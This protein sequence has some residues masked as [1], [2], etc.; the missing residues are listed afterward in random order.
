MGREGAYG[1]PIMSRIVGPQPQRYA[2]RKQRGGNIVSI[3]SGKGGVGKTNL[4]LNFGIVLARQGGQPVLLDAD[5][6]LANADILLDITPVAG[7]A[8]LLDER[9][10]VEDLL[11]VAPGGLRVLCGVSGFGDAARL[12]PFTDHDCLRGL[13]R[14]QEACDTLLVDCGAGVNATIVSVALASDLLVMVTTP[15]PTSLA[16][17]YGTLKLLAHHGFCGRAGVVVNMARSPREADGVADRLRHVAHEFLG[18]TVEP[19]GVVPFDR[20]VLEAVRAR[21]PVVVRA[22]RCPASVAI[23]GICRR[24]A[25]ARLRSGRSGGL[26]SRVAS[27]FV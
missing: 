11:A 7:F 8:E 4:A 26:W 2:G 6:G 23:A 16:D 14:L 18:L 21:T 13:Q 5:F 20:Q 1:H 9:R 10:S 15:E 25:P 12:R 3:V 17:S 19:L 22:P 27:L 24:I